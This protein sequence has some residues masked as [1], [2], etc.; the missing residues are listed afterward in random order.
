MQE[1]GVGGDSSDGAA[2]SPEESLS[3]YQSGAMQFP[4]RRSHT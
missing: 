3:R 1:A 4:G 2:N